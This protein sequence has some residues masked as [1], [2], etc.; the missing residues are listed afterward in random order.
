MN[1]L[2]EGLVPAHTSYEGVD[3]MRV[4]RRIVCVGG[5]DGSRGKF[6]QTV[7]LFDYN[8]NA[9]SSLPACR[10]RPSFFPK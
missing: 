2:V 10:R 6:M 8:A 9:L 4:Q 3:V 5:V 7:V 1:R